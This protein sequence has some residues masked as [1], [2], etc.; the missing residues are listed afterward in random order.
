[1]GL[2]VMESGFR[3]PARPWLL[4]LM[5]FSISVDYIFLKGVSGLPQFRI[6]EL[7]SYV[8]LVFIFLDSVIFFDR[9]ISEY[10][11]FVK[12]SIFLH[13]YFFWV[14]LV[15][16][17]HFLSGSGVSAIAQ[18]KDLIPSFILTLI[19]YFWCDNKGRLH[20]I[21]K[22][23]L[24][25]IFINSLLGTLQGLFGKPRPIALSETSAFKLDV[26]GKVVGD[27]MA[28]G[29]FGHPNAFAL[30]M[31]AGAV[32]VFLVLV[33][34]I[35]PGRLW[36]IFSLLITPLLL[37]SLY[38]T[39]GKG[40]MAWVAVALGFSFL[41]PYFG[42]LKWWACNI[43]MC[44]IVAAIVIA[45]IN[46]SEHMTSFR[47]IFTRI[48]LWNAAFFALGGDLGSFFTGGAQYDILKWSYRFTGGKFIYPNAHNG[49]IN[50]A[51][52]Y[53]V[54]ALIFYVG[55]VFATTYRLSK[56]FYDKNTLAFQLPGVAT[57]VMASIFGL[58]G[59]YFFE[60]TSE[61]VILQAQFFLL[62]GLAL[63]MSRSVA[64]ESSS[65]PS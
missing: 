32:L 65:Y 39:H 55:M 57:F 18:F 38:K 51:V 5:I 52:F 53:G 33:N 19:I 62:I 37:F 17:V 1:M 50:Q 23:L 27:L 4:Y 12:N 14:A 42:R 41:M 6:I 24:V 63:A 47:T 59:E 49:I 15:A 28:T 40:A 9:L 29:W 22:I 46:L 7:T 8:V 35:N 11:S 16:I 26:D 34:R 20:N 2:T 54:P 31:I 56:A 10:R 21:V 25:G 13:L 36:R 61:G 64:A 60:P 30:Y 58:L 45:A 48:Q 3:F 43:A 44:S